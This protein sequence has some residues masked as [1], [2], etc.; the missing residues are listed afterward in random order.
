M[1][2]VI[3]HYLD[4]LGHRCSAYYINILAS[5]QFQMCLFLLQLG[6]VFHIKAEVWGM[7]ANQGG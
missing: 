2:Q 7:G 5:I 3:T 6:V 1:K 4:V